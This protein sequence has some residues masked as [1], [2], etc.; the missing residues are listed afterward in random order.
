[1][2]ELLTL[3]AVSY[4]LFHPASKYDIAHSSSKCYITNELL[5]SEPQSAP[6]LHSNLQIWK[7]RQLE[8]LPV[9][10][11]YFSWYC[12]NI[13]AD[14]DSLLICHLSSRFQ[15]EHMV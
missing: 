4:C 5:M 1:M 6:L 10:S 13:K 7:T 8:L 15:P 3:Q 2:H 14:H 12:G 9:F 11:R